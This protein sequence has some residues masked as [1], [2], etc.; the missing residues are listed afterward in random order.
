MDL[1]LSDE[2]E[3]NVPPNWM[4][5]SYNTQTDGRTK[6]MFKEIVQLK[7]I[8]YFQFSFFCNFF[9]WNTYLIRS[10][11]VSG[12]LKLSLYGWWTFLFMVGDSTIDSYW[13][14]PMIFSLIWFVPL[15]GPNA[16][17]WLDSRGER[18]GTK[19]LNRDS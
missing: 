8:V 7:S 11:T 9:R 17:C 6:F 4:E 18:L 13:E 2:L 10:A 1:V 19:W 12:G 5:F 15:P 14:E 3:S 16:W